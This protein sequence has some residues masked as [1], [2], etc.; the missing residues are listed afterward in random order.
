MVAAPVPGI[1]DIELNN[2]N[3]VWINYGWIIF[4]KN[5]FTAVKKYIKY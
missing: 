4:R 2:G 3:E 1:V 5:W